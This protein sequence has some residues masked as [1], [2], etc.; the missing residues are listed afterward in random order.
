MPCYLKKGQLLA[1]ASLSSLIFAGVTCSSTDSNISVDG[2]APADGP[3]DA[4]AE[5]ALAVDS[6]ADEGDHSVSSSADGSFG[7]AG[8]DVTSADVAAESSS[9]DSN[10][11]DGPIDASSESVGEAGSIEA[12]LP[13]AGNTC[14]TAG[15][16]PHETCCASGC[17]DKSLD[18][19]NCGG[20]GRICP[21]GAICTNGAC[22]G[23]D[24]GIAICAYPNVGCPNGDF[25]G[26]TI[27]HIC[28]SPNCASAP[29]GAPCAYGPVHVGNCC[30][31][32]CVNENIDRA[33]C[34]GCGNTCPGVCVVGADLPELGNRSCLP[35]P[36]TA[37][38]P[39]GCGPSEACASG[40]CLPVVCTGNQG[41]A[42]PDGNAGMCCD[43]AGGLV[44]KDLSTD[45]QNC[46]G[47]NFVCSSGQT[48]VAGVCSGAQSPC[49]GGRFDA[50][51]DPS[52]VTAAVCCAGG[53][54][55]LG[56]P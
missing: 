37:G 56:C 38:C 36:T 47:C 17:T 12:S 40:L 6:G 50:W 25:C 4:T 26:P 45:P 13:E 54:C 20:C 39:G 1:C 46:G 51:C 42:A 48:C 41:C 24:G 30:G 23:T 29:E 9:V 49:R 22:V 44:C 55:K 21:V 53:E 34:G 18:P 27:P 14:L 11:E 19:A 16:S 32:Q 52:G 33:N 31:G 15:C 35:L 43:T 7:D 8:A 10:A 2:S 28:Y 3:M 5:V